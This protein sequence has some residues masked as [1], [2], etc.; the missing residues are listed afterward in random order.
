[1]QITGLMTSSTQPNFLSSTKISYLGDFTAETNGT[2][3]KK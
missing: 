2:W 3:Q 1:M